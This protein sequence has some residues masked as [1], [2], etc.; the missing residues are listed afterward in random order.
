MSK[1]E[2]FYQLRDQYR[3]MFSDDADEELWKVKEKT[4]LRDELATVIRDSV[5][6][7]LSEVRSPIRVTIDY[8]PKGDIA[9]KVSLKD[10]ADTSEVIETPSFVGEQPAGQS[11]SKSYSQRSE[12]VGFTV[13]FPD[14]TVV[15]RK[16]AKETMIATLKVIGL[17]KAAAFHGRLFKGFPLVGRNRRTDVDFRCQELVDGW[18]IYINMSNDTKIEMLR[19]ISDEMRLGLVIKD[20]TGS[21]VT[22]SADSS[23]RSGNKQPG[24][25]TLYKLNGDGPYSKRELVL[26]AVTQYVMEHADLNYDQLERVFPKNLQGSYGVIRPMSWIEEKASV[27]FDHN[28][29]YYTDSKDLLTSADGIKFAVCKEWGDNFSNFAHQV[30]NLGWEISEG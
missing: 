25:R 6:Q 18:Y 12:S 28:N 11:A 23:S 27:G 13:K 15:Q 2:D 21:D 14:G 29:R 8:E 16:N 26:L 3:E 17:H 19:Q 30:E 1:I 10:T 5:A 7:V 4:F 9:V 20:E 24:K 22:F